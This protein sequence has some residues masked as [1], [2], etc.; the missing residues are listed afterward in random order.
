MSTR[1]RQ[2]IS[3]DLTVKGRGDN[4]NAVL[5][6]EHEVCL[7]QDFMDL[8]ANATFVGCQMNSTLKGKTF[9]EMPD[10]D[11]QDKLAEETHKDQG[12]SLG[13]KRRPR[14][15]HSEKLT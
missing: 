3:P 4:G 1:A 2:D 8:Q 11:R 12:L 13:S 6:S 5:L 15:K 7:Q 14:T 9:L 10:K